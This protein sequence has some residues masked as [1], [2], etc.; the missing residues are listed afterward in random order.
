MKSNVLQS[1]NMSTLS[2][3][4]VL[5]CALAMIGA[6]FTS[7]WY[8]DL[9]APQYPEGLTL[10]IWVNGLRGNVE[11]INNLNHY[12]GMAH[13]TNDTF[14]EFKILPWLLGV[15]I[16]GGVFVAWKNTRRSL[17]YYVAALVLIALVASVDFWLWE[18]KY[19][20]NLDPKAAI[21]VPGMAYQPPFLGY[22]QLLNFLAGSLPDIGGWLI[23]G[24]AIIMGIVFGYEHFLRK[25]ENLRSILAKSPMRSLFKKT[26]LLSLMAC[27]AS[28]QPIHYGQDACDHCKMTIVDNK[29]GAEIITDKS[30]VFRFDSDECLR[31]F[32]QE[33]HPQGKQYLVTDYVKPGE[34][35]DAK[36]AWFLHSDKIKSPMGGNLAAFKN[37]ADAE[38]YQAKLGGEILDWNS[39]INSH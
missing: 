1:G 33:K 20:H 5:L 38:S 24:P 29:F 12:I 13:L 3:M 4:I 14:P 2:R 22:K 15:M 30:K 34:I 39:F 27:S 26:A 18:Y 9:E 32:E 37:K 17:F 25:K 10:E 36:T 6:Y 19:G 7:V 23:I 35:I 8:V 28:L 16:A 11:S 31:N 21:K